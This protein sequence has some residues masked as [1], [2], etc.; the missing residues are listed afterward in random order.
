MGLGNGADSS[1]LVSLKASCTVRDSGWCLEVE[2]SSES[3]SIIAAGIVLLDNVQF[4][5]TRPSTLGNTE[6]SFCE[7]P[8][9]YACTIP[10]NTTDRRVAVTCKLQYAR[11]F[12]RKSTVCVVQLGEQPEGETVE[13]E[14]RDTRGK[15]LTKAVALELK[16]GVK[17]GGRR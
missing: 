7:S 8:G 4:I 12:K 14:L 15:L 9:P 13:L 5:F 6:S 16:Q 3:T 1:V 10:R 2:P 17:G 11:S